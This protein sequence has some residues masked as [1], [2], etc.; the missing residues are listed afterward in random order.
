MKE[1][2]ILIPTLNEAESIGEVIREFKEL[3]FTNIF[4]IDGHS[5]DPTREIAERE[6]VRLVIQKGKGKGTAVRQAFDLIEDDVI[7]MIDGDKTYSPV[8]VRTLLAPILNDEADHVIGNRFGFGG[9]F[10][11][12]HRFGNWALNKVFTLGYDV[13]L[14]DILSGYRALTKD[15]V[16]R[17]NL[18]KTGF[19]IE[20]EMAIKSVKQGMRIKEV[21][22]SY[23]KRKGKA[24]LNTFRDGFKILSTLYMLAKTQNPLFYFGILGTFFITAGIISGVY[25]VLEWYGGVT[26][27]LLTVL[28]ALLIISGVQFFILGMLGDLLV[29]IQRDTIEILWNRVMK[30]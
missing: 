8:E 18:E 9:S 10:S 22:I 20:A 19:E 23:Q 13:K 5:T 26:H 1:V 27:I 6:G 11:P 7:V 14:H 21:P 29:S 28:T 16:S 15:C 4:V 30:K 3:G 2:C 17:L 24:K 25:V 12:L